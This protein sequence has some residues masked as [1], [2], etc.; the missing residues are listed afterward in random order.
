VRILIAILIFRDWL[1]AYTHRKRWFLLKSALN[2]NHL[3]RT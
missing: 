2:D 1:N 3:D